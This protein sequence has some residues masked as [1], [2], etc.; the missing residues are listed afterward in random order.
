MSRAKVPRRTARK[1]WTAPG[2]PAPDSRRP[3]GSVRDA[4]V[5]VLSEADGD[6]RVRD[7]Q[8]G[9]ER[10]LGGP[11]SPTSVKGIPAPW[12]Q[13]SHAALRVPRYAGLPS[14]PRRN[15]EL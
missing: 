10:L 4:I 14:M 2:E 11:V 7:I 9:V 5:Q 12:L 8:A 15:G 6:L 3:F 1:G 13:S